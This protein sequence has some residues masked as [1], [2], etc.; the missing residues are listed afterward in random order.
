[1][2]ELPPV[3]VLPMANDRKNFVGLPHRANLKCGRSDV[4]YGKHQI[5]AS[6]LFFSSQ[7]CLE[8][9][10]AKRTAH[11]RGCNYWNKEDGLFDRR[12]DLRFP[13]RTGRDR[14]PV[15]PNSKGTGTKPQLAA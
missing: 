14:L 7:K 9:E 12:V 1:M 13:K 2:A 6:K 8:F 5:V 11:R 10:T 15:L 3:H 4:K